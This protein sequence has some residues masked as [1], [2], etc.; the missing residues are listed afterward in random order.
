MITLNLTTCDINANWLRTNS[1]H[2]RAVHQFV[3]ELMLVKSW[4]L[5]DVDF[6]HSHEIEN[7]THVSTI[8]H[9]FWNQG[10]TPFIEQ[11]GV[12]H[13]TENNSDHEPIYCVIDFPSIETLK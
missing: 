3:S 10:L 8:D 13:L 4:D 12:L 6:T 2:V 11:C 9:F 7:T 1:G 5:F